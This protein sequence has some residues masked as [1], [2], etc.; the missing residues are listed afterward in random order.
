[1]SAIQLD[2]VGRMDHLIP[3]VFRLPHRTP[4]RCI[5]AIG[6]AN[7]RERSFACLALLRMLSQRDVVIDVGWAPGR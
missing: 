1:M 4:V 7:A 2:P 3:F 6:S 5:A